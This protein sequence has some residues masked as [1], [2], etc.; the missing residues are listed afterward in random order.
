[1]AVC[2]LVTHVGTEMQKEGEPLHKG[3][4]WQGRRERVLVK[5]PRISSQEQAFQ[6]EIKVNNLYFCSV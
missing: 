5:S 2:I 3:R 4:G 6:S 1:M